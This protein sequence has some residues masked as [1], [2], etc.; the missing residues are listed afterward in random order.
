MVPVLRFPEFEGEWKHK[1]IGDLLEIGSGKD[2]KDLRK[3]NIPVFGTGGYMTSV[4]KYLHDG[5]SVAIGRKGTIDKPVFLEGKFWT[6]DT[7]FYTHSFRNCFPEFVYY[8]FNRVNWLKYNEATGVPSLSKGTIE[9]IKI[10]IP[11]SDE[12]QKIAAFLGAV[13]EKIAA[14]RKK[15][16]LLEDYKKGWMQKLFSQ[17][18]RFKDDEGKDFPDWEEGRL[19]HLCDVRDGTHDSPKYQNTG[20]PLITSK[21]L[22]PSGKLD[23]ENVSYISSKDY[24]DI[25]KRSKVD[26]GDIL[27][28]MIGTIGN[29]VRVD[30]DCFAIKNVALIK[31]KTKLLLSYLIHYLSSSY[32][33]KQFYMQNAGGTQKF[34][35]LG[36]IREIRIKFPNPDEQKKIADFLAALDD[37]ISLVSEELDKAKAFKKGLLQQMFV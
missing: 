8:L 14:F 16:A 22:L 6:V 31:K 37:K 36:I 25:N 29:P 21:N 27:F 10:V 20:H 33:A 19:G 23:M 32:I 24:E 7:L 26:V 28:G 35:S 34:L 17:E 15:K 13:D 3:G 2:Y 1:K 18:L 11:L 9:K 5:K 30:R 12:Q 4:N